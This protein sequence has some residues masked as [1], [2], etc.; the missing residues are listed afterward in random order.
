MRNLFWNRT[1]PALA[2]V[3]LF[4]GSAFAAKYEIQFGAPSLRAV[5]ASL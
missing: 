5:L 1:L 2:L 3:L 4:S